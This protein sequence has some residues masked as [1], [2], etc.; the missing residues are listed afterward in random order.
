MELAAKAL[1]E[2]QHDWYCWHNGYDEG[3]VRALRQTYDPI[4]FE[5]RVD[6]L[7]SLTHATF[8]NLRTLDLSSNRLSENIPLHLLEN[9]FKQFDELKLG[10]NPWTC[11]CA[12]T[13][14]FRDW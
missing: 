13:V 6:A 11:D 2:K 9:V 4:R 5:S 1:S 3:F 14:V 8:G 10:D 12:E 7:E